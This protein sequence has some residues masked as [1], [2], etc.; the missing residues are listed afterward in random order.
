MKRELMF[1]NHGKELRL[2]YEL[3]SIHAMNS[4]AMHN[5]ASRGVMFAS[6]WGQRIVFDGVEEKIVVSGFEREMAKTSFKVRMPESGRIVALVDRYPVNNIARGGFR[7]NPETSV[8]VETESSHESGQANELRMFTLPAYQS[9]HPTYGFS[10]KPTPNMHFLHPNARIEKDTVF[11]ESPCV[12]P[13]GGYATGINFNVAFMSIPGVGEDGIIITRKALN[14]MAHKVI[15]RRTVKYGSKN[16][17]LNIYGDDDNYLAFPEIGDFVRPDGVLMALR[18]YTPGI[19]STIMS[20]RATQRIDHLFDKCVYVRQVGD[21]NDNEFK[22]E[23]PGRVI[24]IRVLRRHTT[25]QELPEAMME[26]PNRYYQATVNY[27]QALK[28]VEK[29]LQEEYNRRYRASVRLPIVGDFH[30]ELVMAEAILGTPDPRSRQSVILNH[31]KEPLDEVMIEFVI[32]YVVVP[33]I[34]SKLSDFHGGK[35]VVVAIVEDEKDM[36]TD[37]YGNRADVMVDSASMIGRMNMGRPAEMYFNSVSR[38]IRR[39]LRNMMGYDQMSGKE[40]SPVSEDIVASLPSMTF[41]LMWR[42]IQDMCDIL[43][44]EVSAHYRAMSQSERIE[45]ITSSL[46]KEVRMVYPITRDEFTHVVTRKLEQRFHPPRGPVKYRGFSGEIV[47]TEDHVRVAP[48]Y[49]IL[50]NKNT[51]EWASLSTGTLQPMGLPS[52]LNREE[53]YSKPWRPAFTRT[54]S[55]T[56]GRIYAGYAGREAIIEWND[57]C[58]NP[59]TMRNISYKLISS[60]NPSNIDFAPDRDRVPVGGHRGL[61]LYKHMLFCAGAEI[62]YTQ[63]PD[64][65]LRIHDRY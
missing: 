48:L 19:A 29:Q 47:E 51:D 10:F 39:R 42:E 21:K 34:G 46:N 4:F 55:E 23:K 63:S 50:L 43:H 1:D 62:R 40:W 25:N 52:P 27:Y 38:E 20:K 37:I 22:I 14:R 18:D 49:M 53:K 56:E 2:R 7:F 44:P 9:F 33:D 28:T 59:A 26:Q 60:T 35:G 45:I 31:R 58:S 61:Q 64:F 57:R 11:M 6:H 17:A 3:L 41:E 8:I 13:N 16:F 54:I 15:E 32:E 12:T 36:P 5:S 65:Q 24:D 30:R